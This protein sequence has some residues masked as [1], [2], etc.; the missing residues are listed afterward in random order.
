MVITGINTNDTALKFI[1]VSLSQVDKVINLLESPL[2]IEIVSR[3][4]DRDN[5]GLSDLLDAC[6]D[7]LYGS[8]E[9]MSR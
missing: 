3:T 2:R 7:V 4:A 6:P 9:D 1:S 5:D 8:H